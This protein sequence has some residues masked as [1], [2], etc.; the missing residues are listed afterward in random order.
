MA[1]GLTRRVTS[2]TIKWLTRHIAIPV[3]GWLRSGGLPGLWALLPFALAAYLMYI[4]HQ[5]FVYHVHSLFSTLYGPAY[6]ATVLAA[7][8]AGFI[9]IGISI[10]GD[11]AL[12]KDNNW[13]ISVG[14]VWSLGMLFMFPVIPH[15]LFLWTYT[16][17]GGLLFFGVI[18]FAKPF[19]RRVTL[20]VWTR[21]AATMDGFIERS[22]S[23][24]SV[25]ES[26]PTD[27]ALA[28][29]VIND[30]DTEASKEEAVQSADRPAQQMDKGVVAVFV[31][32]ILA[33]LVIVIATTTELFNRK[34]PANDDDPPTPSE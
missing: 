26:L 32:L 11:E 15:W 19:L 3:A 30:H 18:Q 13:W 14:G 27:E 24:E 29:E 2:P 33:F 23:L 21:I 6:W 12:R 4:A 9:V 20:P 34:K 10:R 7:F 22:K 5:G 31:L 28:G 17:L 1:D 8:L 16:L 25:V